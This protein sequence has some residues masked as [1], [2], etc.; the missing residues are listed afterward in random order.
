MYV[1]E[2]HVVVWH[3]LASVMG[4]CV[5]ANPFVPASHLSSIKTIFSTNF[6]Q[7]FEIVTKTSTPAAISV[8]TTT[9]THTLSFNMHN[10]TH[11]L[12]KLR[13]HCLF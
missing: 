7:I 10:H 3:F 4:F 2:E 9:H 6:P 5:S 11:A 1:M 8:R 12:V 13:L